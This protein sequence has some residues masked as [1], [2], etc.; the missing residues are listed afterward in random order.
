MNKAILKYSLLLKLSQFGAFEITLL[1]L[2]FISFIGSSIYMKTEIKSLVD[3]LTHPAILLITG[4]KFA[5]DSAFNQ[6]SL[7][8]GEY[9][10]LLFTRPI[11]RFSYVLTK[12]FVTAMGSLSMTV[13]FLLLL[14]LAQ[15]LTGNHP[16][17][18]VDGWQLSS[19]LANAWSFGCLL[20]FLRVLPPKLGTL[21]FLFCFYGAV[22]TVFSIGFKTE[23][24]MGVAMRGWE[25]ASIVFHQLFYPCIDFQTVFERSPFSFVPIVTYVS[26]FLL[27]LLGATIV[28]N[29]REFTYAQD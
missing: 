1:S 23:S 4:W 20:M 9:F 26:N 25:T 14:L 7:N 28:I 3:S 21:L 5:Q 10:S 27:Y 29:K 13:S 18:F 15:V 12:A 17:I 6:N 16:L 11:T 19:L 2:A 8:D 22:G 24:T